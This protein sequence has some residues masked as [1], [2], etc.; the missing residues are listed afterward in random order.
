MR[1]TD[2]AKP[3][4]WS[5]L[6]HFDNHYKIVSNAIPELITILN[7]SFVNYEHFS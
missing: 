3:K 4:P 1:N 5:M 6:M 2:F 7:A